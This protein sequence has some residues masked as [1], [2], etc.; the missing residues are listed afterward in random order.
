M[1]K[2]K[3][4]ENYIKKTNELKR[5]VKHDEHVLSHVD[6]IVWVYKTN[7]DLEIVEITSVSYVTKIKKKNYTVIYYDNSH[8]GVMHRHQRVSVADESDS[9]VLLH[10]TKKGHQGKLMHWAIKDIQRNWYFY[11]RNFFKRSGL[12]IDF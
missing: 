3:N 1:K 12:K 6:K 7:N 10:V 2:G 4:R 5:I 11:K 8:G 9:P